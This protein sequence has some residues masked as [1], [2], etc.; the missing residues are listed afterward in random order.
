MGVLTGCFSEHAPAA[1]VEGQ[2]NVPLGEGVAGSIVIVIDRFTFGPSE[3]RVRAGDRVTWVNCDFE[4]HTSTAGGG[5]W[6]S[7]LLAPG[8]GF[9]QTFGTPGEFSYHCEPHLF[10]TGGGHRPV[11]VGRL[12]EFRHRAR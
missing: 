10:M 8:D 4:S 7:P 11:S 2:C 9:T 12:L 6:A 1:P 3:L 5:Q